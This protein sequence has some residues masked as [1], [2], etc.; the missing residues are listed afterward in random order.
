M[1]K[2]LFITMANGMIY[3]K[4][5]IFHPQEKLVKHLNLPKL[6]AHIGEEIQKMKC[7]KEYM[8]HVGVAKK[9]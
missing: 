5:L 8:A 6:Q 7:Y 2:F 4:V 9:S 3:A 1:T